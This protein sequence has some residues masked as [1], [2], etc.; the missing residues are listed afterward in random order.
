AGE[1]GLVDVAESA[2]LAG[3]LD[4]RFGLAV[5][6][7]LAVLLLTAEGES[8]RLQ[9]H[10]DVVFLTLLVNLLNESELVFGAFWLGWLKLGEQ[11]D[12]VGADAFDLVHAPAGFDLA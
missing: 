3:A 9:E 11:L 5:E 6:E 8:D 2:Q 12:S 1:L 10:Q 4:D 7:A